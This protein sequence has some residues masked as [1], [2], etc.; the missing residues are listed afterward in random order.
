MK[1]KLRGSSRL[2]TEIDIFLL[3]AIGEEYFID[4][5]EK[6]APKIIKKKALFTTFTCS[7]RISG[8][9]LPAFF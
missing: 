4:I 9:N 6:C 7:S 3:N 1:V 8:G 5:Q 2:P